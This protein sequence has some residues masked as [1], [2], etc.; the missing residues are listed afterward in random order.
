MAAETEHGLRD[1]AVNASCLPDSM[2][3]AAI[4]IIIMRH[5]PPAENGLTAGQNESK[6]LIARREHEK[7]ATGPAGHGAGRERPISA[8]GGRKPD[9]HSHLL[10]ERAISFAAFAVIGGILR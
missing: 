2:P 6:R 10:M 4:R 1:I 8:E 7:E 3:P 9:A 5:T